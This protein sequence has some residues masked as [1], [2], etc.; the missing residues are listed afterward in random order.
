MRIILTHEQADFDALASQYAAHLLDP[1]F[2]PVLPNR[3]NRNVRAFLTIY[4]SEFPYLEQRDL[5]SGESIDTVCLVDTQS[6]ITV[7]G[8]ST[9]TK[10]HIVDHHP[11]RE[12]ISSSWTSTIEELGATTTILIEELRRRDGRLSMIEASLLLLGIYED[13]GSLTYSR[14]TARDLQAA[15]Y[16]L[17]QGASLMIVNDFLNHPLSPEQQHIY[18]SLRHAA[19]V[20]QIHGHKIIAAYG[21]ATSVPE[22]LSTIAHKLRDLLDPD[23]IVLLLQTRS[24]V[25]LIARSSSDH[26]DVSEIAA[27]F[28][29]GG[30]DRA[31]AALIRE[32]TL[33]QVSEE[34]ERILPQYVHPA[35]TVAE[36]MSGQPQILSPDTLASEALERMVRFG[37]E[38]Y[39]VVENG[40]VIGLLTRR[41]VDR[42]VSHKLN[43]TAS[44]LMSP[45]DIHVQPT[46][47]IEHLQRV[48]VD[49][50]WGQIPVL[51]SKTGLI[52][53]IVTRTDLFKILTR[54]MKRAFP[55]N[56]SDQL[57]QR[58]P[59]HRLMLLR[60]IADLA[61]KKHIPVYVVGGFVRDLLLDRPSLDFDIVVEGDAI[62]LA[63]ALVNRFGGRITT[64]TRFGTAKWYPEKNNTMLGALIPEETTNNVPEISTEL[65]EFVDLISARTEFYEEPTALPTVVHSS[66][67]LDLHRRDFTIN[68]LALRL[69]GT[70]YGELYD[71]WGGLNDLRVGLVRV[72]HSLSFVDDPTRM[73]R[74]VRYEGR[75]GFQIEARTLRLLREALPLVDRVSGERL[76]S[77][78]EH[79]LDEQNS[80]KMLSRLESLG[81][82]K[83]IHASLK[84]DQAVERRLR[85][86]PVSPPD[87]EWGLSGHAWNEQQHK[88]AF[89]LWLLPLDEE[90]AQGLLSRLNYPQQEARAILAAIKLSC[91]LNSLA[92][93]PIFDIVTQLDEYRPLVIFANYL[94][95]VDTEIKTMLENYLK[96]W[97]KVRPMINGHDLRRLGL[98]P[99]PVYR[100]ILNGLRKAWLEGRIVSAAQEQELLDELLFSGSDN[101][102]TN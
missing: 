67:K 10:V 69:D 21:D 87:S 99:S 95:A 23:A 25:Q 90:E 92:K 15:A 44:S 85:T 24:G 19:K 77:E 80:S 63:K 71:Y 102:K 6:M 68:T 84:Y 26:I 18:D 60:E 42:A 83:T 76:H 43:L 59:A 28:G 16:L 55:V 9:Q 94:C 48:M 51:D 8:I 20:L 96:H 62:S 38:G 64:H 47:S 36:I 34:F 33:Q 31:A 27:Y 35:V 7:K 30:H 70:H 54:Q 66:I 91:S 52:L 79:I 5:T 97:R 75:Y 29:G 73:L 39:P 93:L 3:M 12:D 61:H 58:L 53:G 17:D 2:I 14:T 32:Q 11:R 41:A 65:P 100:E 56:L 37:Y 57:S 49:T 82:L 78:L 81:L 88:L 98:A 4:G 13:T 50:G 22:E 46:D 45:G 101:M 74:A 86:L 1:E 40:K 89:M 72:L